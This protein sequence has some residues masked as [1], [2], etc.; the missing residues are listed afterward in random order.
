MMFSGPPGV[1]LIAPST[2]IRSPACRPL[3]DEPVIAVPVT[4]FDHPLLGFAFG[5]DH[6]HEVA[7]GP[8][9][10]AFCGTR[11]AFGLVAPMARARTNWP[12]RNWP[13]GLASTART[14]KVPV[15]WL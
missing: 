1:T 10:T 3:G 15:S 12:G 2:T 11:M 4:H 5:I 6:P 8:S 13:L 9:R 14:R 7:L